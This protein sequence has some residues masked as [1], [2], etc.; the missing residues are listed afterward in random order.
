MCVQAPNFEYTMPTT[1]Q[2]TLSAQG[3]LIYPIIENKIT[4]YS[5]LL[6]DC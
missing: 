2:C 6:Y 5:V 3:R 4:I 1:A